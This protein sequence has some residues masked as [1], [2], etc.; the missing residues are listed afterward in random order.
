M[1]SFHAITNLVGSTG[2]PLLTGL[3][4]FELDKR[5]EPLYYNSAGIIET[6]GTLACRYDKMHLVMFGEYVPYERLLPFLKKVTPIAGSFVPGDAPCGLALETAEGT[7]TF[8]PLICFEDVF[9]YVARGM[10]RAG[11]DILV[12]FTNDGWFRSSPEPF[13]HAALSAFRA[14][15][16]RRPLVRATNSGISTAIDRMGRITAVFDL[17]GRKTEVGGVMFATVALHPPEQTF[18]ALYGDWLLVVWIAFAAV[19]VTRAVVRRR[20]LATLT[21]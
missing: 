2:I 16:T 5:G 8:G 10:A 20:L 13:Q 11:A 9:G 21:Q 19:A 1:L 15:E 3:P 14:I 4:W 12:N 7:V 17:H 18:Y 6:N